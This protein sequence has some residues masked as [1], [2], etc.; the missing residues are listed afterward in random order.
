MPGHHDYILA[1]W[2]F[3]RGNPFLSKM[4]YSCKRV[5]MD[6]EPYKFGKQ[7]KSNP[8]GLYIYK[9]PLV[10]FISCAKLYVLITVS[11]DSMQEI[12]PLFHKTTVSL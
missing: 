12:G 6:E 11:F 5:A 1:R 3:V 4:P 7:G 10:R 8:P 9:T 2:S